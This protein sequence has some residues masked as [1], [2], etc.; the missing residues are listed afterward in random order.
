MRQRSMRAASQAVSISRPS[1]NPSASIERQ[2]A[3][4]SAVVMAGYGAGA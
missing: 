2:S 3:A 4:S 1:S